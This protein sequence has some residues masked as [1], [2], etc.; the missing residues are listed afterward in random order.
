MEGSVP[1][2]TPDAPVRSRQESAPQGRAMG[3]SVP[4]QT[5]NA[6]VRAR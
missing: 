4:A 3:D 2:Q 1:A 6:P 5:P